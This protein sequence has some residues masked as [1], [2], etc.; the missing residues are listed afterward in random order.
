MSLISAMDI[1]ASG[2][3][4]ERQ[5]ME[6]IAQNIANIETTKTNEGGVYRRKVV[7]FKE[8]L[9]KELAG[10]GNSSQ[11]VGNGVQVSNIIADDSP[12]IMVYDPQHPDADKDGFV[13]KP[14]INLA[15]EIVDSISASRA[16]GANVTVLNATK[17]LALKALSIGRG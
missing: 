14:N 13:A 3:N 7:V 5:R 16:Y 4:C 15:N 17:A 6:I 2:L 9:Q 12:P 11:M 1:S 8:A 10:N